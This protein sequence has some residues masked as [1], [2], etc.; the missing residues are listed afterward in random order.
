MRFGQATVFDHEVL[1]A[2]P[3]IKITRCGIRDARSTVE[4]EDTKSTAVDV[5][6]NTPFAAP[7]TT[8]LPVKA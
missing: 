5:V 8:K 7:S 6:T 4:E 2:F 1:Q 3:L